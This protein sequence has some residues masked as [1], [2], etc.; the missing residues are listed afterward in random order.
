MNAAE[1]YSHNSNFVMIDCRTGLSVV[2]MESYEKQASGA[3]FLALDRWR[4]LKVTP[5]TY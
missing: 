5:I 2:E 4:N 1:L 3:R